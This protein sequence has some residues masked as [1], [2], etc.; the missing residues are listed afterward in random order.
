[1]A[2]IAAYISKRTKKLSFINLAIIIL[3][4]QLI[5]TVFESVYFHNVLRALTDFT[6]GWPGL[7]IQLV[8]GYFIIR[9]LSI[10]D[11]KA[12]ARDYQ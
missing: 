3:G 5:G 8:F 9:G 7:L 4:Y 1:M 11:K 2:I 6:I 10:N 12:D